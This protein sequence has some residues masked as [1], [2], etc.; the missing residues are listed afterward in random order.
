MGQTK[1]MTFKYI[2]KKY[3]KIL[4]DMLPFDVDIDYSTVEVMSD[5]LITIEAT[6][7]KPDIII[8]S[9][10]VIFMIEFETSH[11]N[12]KRKKRFKV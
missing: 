12:I 5:E 2:S 10:K 3:L 8:K 1:D 11:V 6:T 9:D 7:F 4:I